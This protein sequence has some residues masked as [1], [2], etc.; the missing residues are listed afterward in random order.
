[1]SQT[2]QELIEAA[3]RVL[4]VNYMSAGELADGLEALQ[5]MLR[6]WSVEGISVEILNEIDHTLSAGVGSYT[7]GPAGCDIDSDWVV[8]V[9]HGFCRIGGLDYPLKV[10]TEADYDRIAL[11]STAGIPS[12]IFYKPTY[13]NGQIN[14]YYVPEGAYSMVLKASTIMDEPSALANEITF[15]PY[16]DSA[17]K[18][19]LA[20]NLAPEYG[21]NPSAIVIAQAIYTKS[22][23][24]ARNAQMRTSEVAVEITSNY[25]RFNIEEG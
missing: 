23:I 20:V 24:E 25:H 13:P 11:K 10:L 16:Y 1:M 7:I 15:A 19:N 3:G 22:V 21:K 8:E 2:A 12:K 9:L 18:W 14:L 5:I 4:S 17:I 6:S